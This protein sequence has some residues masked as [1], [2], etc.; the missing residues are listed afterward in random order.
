MAS[1]PES[2]SA[3][4]GQ[5]AQSDTTEPDEVASTIRRSCHRLNEN[6]HAASRERHEFVPYDYLCRNLTGIVDALRR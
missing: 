6:V 1:L 3:L 5:Y 4:C 2:D